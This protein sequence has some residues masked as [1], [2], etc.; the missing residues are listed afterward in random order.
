MSLLR[1]QEGRKGSTIKHAGRARTVGSAAAAVLVAAGLGLGASGTAAAAP[2]AGCS[3]AG[4]TV[5]DFRGT[6]YTTTY[7]N[8]YE[9]G[10]LVR[11]G[12]PVYVYSGYLY[13]GQNWFACQVKMEGVENPP[14]GEARNDWWLWTQGDIAN[15]DNGWGWFPATKVSGGGNY[16]PIP[17]LR[18]C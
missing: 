13:A 10:N 2:A 5:T 9:G 6:T 8:A 15:A 3:G 11:A 17:G 18:T 12:Y 4:P 16:E 14:V 7:C 1:T